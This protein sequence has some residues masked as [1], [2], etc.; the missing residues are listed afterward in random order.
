MTSTHGIEGLT[1]QRDKCYCFCQKLGTKAMFLDHWEYCRETRVEV[2]IV[3]ED[4]CL[5]RLLPFW[6]GS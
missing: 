3:A 6:D 1:F 4:C 2:K 5:L